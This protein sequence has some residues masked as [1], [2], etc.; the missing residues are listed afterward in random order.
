M[1]IRT[2]NR[3][4][5][6][7][8]VEALVALF[9][10]MVGALGIIKLN[11][12]LLGGT[13]IAKTRAEAVQLG[14]AQME[15]I[16]NYALNVGCPANGDSTVSTIN[17][18]NAQFALQSSV[19]SGPVSPSIQVDTCVSWNGSTTPCATESEKSLIMKSY[20]SC[21]GVGTS[22]LIGGSS[23]SGIVSNLKNPTGSAHV[24]GK[25]FGSIPTGA[26]RQTINGVSDNI[27]IY[28]DGTSTYLL[29]KNGKALLT[30]DNASD[31]TF[32]TIS[33]RV[34]I[35][36]KSNGDPIV[37]PTGS[38]L[39]SDLDDNVF[40]LSSDASYCSRYFPSPLPQS[41][42]TGSPAYRYFYYKCYVSKGW[43]GNIGVVRLDNPNT[44]NRVCLG[45]PT[46]SDDSS[47]WSRHAQLST[48]RGYRA[49][50]LLSG[51][52]STA[53]YQTIGIGISVLDGTTYT[54]ANIPDNGIH[55]GTHDFLI[56]TITGDN[57]SCKDSGQMTL[58][59]TSNFTSN[60]G[61]YYCMARATD[62]TP[63]CQNLSIPSSSPSTLIHGTI[64]KSDSTASL[65]TFSDSDCLSTTWTDNG[66]SY[67]YSCILNWTGFSGSR[68][69][70]SLSF[71][72]NSTN[73]TLCASGSTSTVTP[74][75]A[76][77]AY[78]IND[79]TA[80][81]TPN[82]VVFT[83]IPISVTDITL[84]FNI[85]KPSC[86]TLGQPN[87]QWA[88][89]NSPR[90]LTWSNIANA[91]TYIVTTCTTNSTTT[92]TPSGTGAAQSTLSYTP[93]LTGI[94]N[95]SKTFCVNVYATD[96]TSQYANSPVS[97]TKC[98]TG[99]NSN[100][101]SVSWSYQ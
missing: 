94:S 95:G 89:G 10:V 45:D 53:V 23:D 46:F 78:T 43:W 99:T 52:G 35:E 87:V 19:V 9:V 13:G 49:S 48:S 79:R 84:N 47:T 40:V 39:S 55:L 86:S 41:P 75:T 97:P 30:I 58:S 74:S 32:S 31:G 71:L 5:G 50:Y 1:K 93:V 25:D 24:G 67:T 28:S 96:S 91:T 8:L 59:S 22:G 34:F 66:S 4:S 62:G 68:W 36:A 44:N 27:Y 88:T 98:V 100:G 56:T 12:Y 7:V 73:T 2:I 64:N 15:K 42:S 54:A 65:Q 29:N 51:T 83:D 101:N 14:Q 33:G 16:R 38:D 90:D 17:G 61:K 63:K 6:F 81:T 82:S 11:G 57:A 70:G 37:N 20:V 69:Q 76:S 77:V 80:T 60:Q 92:C 72:A 18:T 21:L 3:L 85:S 26:A